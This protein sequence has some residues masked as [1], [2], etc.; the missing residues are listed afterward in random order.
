M[1]DDNKAA[2]DDDDCNG[3]AGAAVNHGFV[4]TTISLPILMKAVMYL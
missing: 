3:A 4:N 2:Y 1:Y